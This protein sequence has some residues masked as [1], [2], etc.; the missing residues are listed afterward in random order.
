M[1]AG[2]AVDTRLPDSPENPHAGQGSV[3]LDIGGDIGALVVTTPA[4]MVGVEVEI[5]PEGTV[6]GHHHHDHDGSHDHDHGHDHGH[7]AHVAVVRRPVQG[8]EVPALVFGELSA[9][10]YALAEKGA[11]DVR[12]LV[13]V[14]G[15][16]VTSAEWPPEPTDS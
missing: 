15:G 2:T 11:A 10:R 6:F 12:L 13:E 16:E 1:S 3:L 7:L 8:G 5:G 14:R 9:G 4:S